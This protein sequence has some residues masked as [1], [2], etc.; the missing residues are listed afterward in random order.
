MPGGV[1]RS[2]QITSAVQLSIL[3][4]G[5]NQL[6]FRKVLQNMMMKRLLIAILFVFVLTQAG[7]AQFAC[8]RHTEPSGAFSYC[9][10]DGWSLTEKEGYK[11]KLVLGPRK[12]VF[13]PNMN[14]RD[15]ANAGP[16]AAYVAASIKE[17]LTNYEKIGATSVKV[18]EQSN[19]LTTN[20]VAGIRVAFRTEYKGLMI[21]T[22]QYYFSVKDGQKL[23]ITCTSLEEEKVTL[24]PVFDR[25]LKT[26]QLDR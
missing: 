1:A 22:L 6:Y 26:F 20:R 11:Y 18:L 12:E 7:Q 4:F 9:P 5:I 16:L 3:R 17:I 23:I 19:F 2:F 25:T 10:P 13:T 8:K 24:D 14:I 21:R 15:E